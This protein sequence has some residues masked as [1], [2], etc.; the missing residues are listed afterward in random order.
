[1]SGQNWSKS[2]C[3][4]TKEKLP[5]KNNTILIPK[6]EHHKQYQKITKKLSNRQDYDQMGALSIEL[7]W[8]PIICE[9]RS[10]PANTPTI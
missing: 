3:V 9:K 5:K 6:E 10:A 8:R 2:F 7:F 1:M 4:I